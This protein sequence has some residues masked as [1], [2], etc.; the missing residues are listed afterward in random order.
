V[1]K[2][3]SASDHYLI[4]WVIEGSNDGLDWTKLDEQN[5]WDL[6]EESIIHY[7]PI[8]DSS[9]LPFFRYLRLR[10]TARNSNGNDYLVISGIELFGRFRGVG[11]RDPGRRSE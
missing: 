5:T 7:F 4:S 6:S 3:N 1:I 11:E 2:S 9:H 10:Q 8:N